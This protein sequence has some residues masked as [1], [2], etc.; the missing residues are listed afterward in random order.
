[1]QAARYAVT[2]HAAPQHA[3]CRQRHLPSHDA[4]TFA[5]DHQQVR[6][7]ISQAQHIYGQ[8]DHAAPRGLGSRQL[9]CLSMLASRRRGTRR[10]TAQ[11][12]VT[13]RVGGGAGDDRRRA[14]GQP[15]V[16]EAAEIGSSVLW[17][18]KLPQRGW[19]RAAWITNRAWANSHSFREKVLLLSLIY[20]QSLSL[21]S[22]PQNRVCEVPQLSNPFIFGP[23][24]VLEGGFHM[25]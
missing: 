8:I 25:I 23:L 4:Q 15:G 17:S 21:V 19:A 3:C 5:N 13:L 16:S 20:Y 7:G 1:M 10:T 18:T 12:D 11:W 22:H 24:A 2:H 14:G 6:P 9:T